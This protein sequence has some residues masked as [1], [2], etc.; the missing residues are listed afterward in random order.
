MCPDLFKKFSLYFVFWH[1]IL[2]LS[3]SLFINKKTDSLPE[4]L[5][6]VFNIVYF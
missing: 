4:K 2:S 6:P 1:E 3:L 5:S